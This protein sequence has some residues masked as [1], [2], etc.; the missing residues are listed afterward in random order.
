MAVLKNTNDLITQAQ[1]DLPD[2]STQR[3]SPQDVR[4]AIENVAFSSFNKVTDS[5]LVG[6]KAYN[7][8]VTYE[9]GQ[10]CVNGGKIYISNQSTGPGAFNAAHWDLY[11]NLS[12]AQKAKLDFISVT[13]AV[14]LDAIEDA[15]NNVTNPYLNKGLWDASV[16]AFPG[17]G[18]AKNGWTYICSVS[19][20]V[21]GRD[22]VANQDKI[23]SLVN[24]ASTS[25]YT[26]NW[27]K[28]DGSDL[29]TSVNGS[30]GAV[31]VTPNATHTGE[32]T[33]ATALTIDK[34]AISNKT[35]VTL[36]ALDHILIGDASDSDNLKKVLASDFGQNGK[37]AIYDANG[38]PTFY[39]TLDLANAAAVSGDTVTLFTNITVTTAVVLKNN[40]N[41][42]LNGF[43]V[44][45]SQNDATNTVQTDGATGYFG[46][47]YNG[48][49][50]RN[51][52]ANGSSGLAFNVANA[53][54]EIDFEGVFVENTYG[55]A[56][57]C[58]LS[59][60]T[61]N[62]KG[63][64]AK[65]R[66]SGIY[67]EVGLANCEG[68]SITGFGIS[69]APKILNCVG[70][71][72]SGI[73]LQAGEGINST[74][75]TSSGLG[76]IGTGSYHNCNAYNSSG[77]SAFYTSVF[78]FS[79]IGI[80]SA[81]AYGA[82]INSGTCINSYIRSST[83]WAIDAGFIEGCTLVSNGT[84][85]VYIAS[86]GRCF[87]NSI[88]STLNSAGVSAIIGSTNRRIVGNHIKVANTGATCIN[89][90]GTAHYYAN[91]T[92]EGSTTPLVSITQA[93]VNTTDSQGN[94][95]LL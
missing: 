1:T 40:V 4:Q 49:I 64:R 31:S 75:F 88:I 77:Y 18:S 7:T 95:I 27:F 36:D 17:S 29:V 30:T 84:S 15:I 10:G 45:N 72:T 25:T 5:P 37:V 14:D 46:R 66:T 59:G 85:V 70:F 26:G 38:K 24:N 42:N 62:I 2:N 61:Y 33:G 69:G 41:Y 90:G 34:T 89:G 68:T 65:G 71:S 52:R 13:Q 53:L 93:T 58:F 80:N 63:L 3:I 8:L 48:K 20:T 47:I 92:F 81:G 50:L 87:N 44:T 35:L 56:F 54:S 51:G 57:S 21:D 6:L 19:G 12:P 55:G 83:D 86:G 22:F 9:N 16:G 82:P 91:N 28:T 94:L 76:G 43:T 39:S 23:T 11:D 73:G 32:V 79:C 60:T 78:I 67:S 74:G